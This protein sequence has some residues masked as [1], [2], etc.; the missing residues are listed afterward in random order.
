V[1]ARFTR[2]K[3]R[4]PVSFTL[5]DTAN[6]SQPVV[7]KLLRSL[8]SKDSPD[9]LPL[10]VAPPEVLEAGLERF[11]VEPYVS[12]DQGGFPRL[13]WE[14]VREWVE[15][16]DEPL[17][18]NAWAQAELAWLSRLSSSLGAEYRLETQGSAAV[19]STLDANVA[20][21]TLDFMT[22]SLRRIFAVLEGVASSSDWGHDILLVF[23][24]DET[25]YRYVSHFYGED[26]EFAASGGMFINDGCSHFVTMKSD[27]RVVEPVIVHEMTHG[28]LSHLPIPAWLNEGLAVNT[29]RRLSPPLG[30][31][32]LTPRQMHAKHQA[33]WTV[34]N[35]QE[36]WSGKSWLR[37]DDGNMLSYDLARI[38]VS[39]FATEWESFKQFVLVA[40]MSDAGSSSAAEHL[41]VDLGAAVCAILELDPDPAWRPAPATWSEPPERGA[42]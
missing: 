15:G 37:T 12:V 41:G 6:T 7:F 35:I 22:K 14:A 17:R 42:F 30:P 31:D 19:V 29:E 5:G 26:G 25:Y 3:P 40:D 34:E 11:V 27:L 36:F 28:C 10:A 38:L 9:L 33:F 24:D 16:L 32:P 23:E 39:K 21:S 20:R 1:S 4:A 8:L 13:D 2:S 18:A